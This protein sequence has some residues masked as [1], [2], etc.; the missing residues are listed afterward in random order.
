MVGRNSL[1]IQDF[2][3]PV[4]VT[5]YDPTLGVKRSLR[6]V[7]AAL[8]YDD[9]GDG[10]TVILVIHQ[11][12]HVPTMQHNLI[13]PMQ[14]RMNDVQVREIPRFLTDHS[15]EDSHSIVIPDIEDGPPYKIPLSL[16]GIV[17]Y[18]PTR[19]PT[20]QEFNGS[21]DRYELT[22]ES[23]PWEPNTNDFQLQESHAQGNPVPM[24]GI[25]D[26]RR[27]RRPA[28]S[29]ANPC[30]ERD[31]PFSTAALALSD[32]FILGNLNAIHALAAT[33]KRGVLP[34]QL[35]A[36]WGIGVEAARRTI[37]VTT[38]RG[39]EPLRTLRCRVGSVPTI[40]NSV[41]DD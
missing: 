3:R 23:P 19:R 18:F 25:G 37:E 4:D 31:N 10:H 39:L 30:L 7:S 24:H 26:D 5:G 32:E 2:N 20:I 40:D 11:A 15:D 34:G 38:Q 29:R 21:L 16:H 27:P 36:R 1:I 35:A 33:T 17:S 9:P 41:T 8:A 6:T 14:L 28:T 13:T 22:Y 12:I